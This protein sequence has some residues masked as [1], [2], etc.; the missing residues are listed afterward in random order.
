MSRG[1]VA[2]SR[3]LYGKLTG[4]RKKRRPVWQLVLGLTALSA[5]L[6][7]VISY[8]PESPVTISHYEF[9]SLPLFFIL[10]FF[11][12]AFTCSYIFK[13]LRRAIFIAVF[14]EAYLLLRLN[15]LTHI[16]FLIILVCLFLIGDLL[17]GKKN[18]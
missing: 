15:N 11:A 9:P 5:T 6:Y 16:F 8:S 10:L 7:F 17:F 4:M 12:V 18:A 14:L 13:N 2:K 1:G 3:G